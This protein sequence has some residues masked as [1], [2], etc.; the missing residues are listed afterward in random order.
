MRQHG[1]RRHDDLAASRSNNPAFDQYT[2]RGV[3]G[4]EVTEACI[5]TKLGITLAL[6][7]ERENESGDIYIKRSPYTDRFRLYCPLPRILNLEHDNEG[8]AVF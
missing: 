4:R 6:D 3:R 5:D 7:A 1:D 8:L 2:G